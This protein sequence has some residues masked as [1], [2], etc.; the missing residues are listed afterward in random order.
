MESDLMEY[1]HRKSMG[2]ALFFSRKSRIFA[3]LRSVTIECVTERLSQ[4]TAH[5]RL[6]LARLIKASLSELAAAG[7]DLRELVSEDI[8]AMRDMSAR[9]LSSK[10]AMLPFL[11]MLIRLFAVN[12]QNRVA[13][14]SALRGAASRF[15]SLSRSF[16][17][18]FFTLG[19]QRVFIS[20][21][22]DTM[23]MT[24]AHRGWG[25][26]TA[27]FEGC[28]FDNLPAM[29]MPGYAFALEAVPSP[30]GRIQ[31]NM[32]ID[33]RFGSDDYCDRLLS[34]DGWQ[35][36][37]FSCD[38]FRADPCF[39]DYVARLH[40]IGTPR[41][42]ILKEAYSALVNKH[43]LLGG[44]ALT[45]S[46]RDILP[47]ASL[48]RGL[49]ALHDSHNQPHERTEYEVEV[50]EAFD[51]RYAMRRFMTLL[52]ECHCHEFSLLLE[53]ARELYSSEKYKDAIKY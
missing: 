52:S 7:H 23:T 41:V 53:R 17:D 50:L 34:E 42:E 24:T 36:I 28:R 1:T 37:S 38:N 29:P 8:A 44:D 30:D 26:V 4:M 35:E 13:Q 22:A 16:L 39:V 18:N 5:M 31:F 14:L 49:L 21:D 43:S 51:N 33:T 20:L 40:D 47:V 45:A 10:D 2:L 46:E 27:H 6:T 3:D 48:M 12:E 11:D 9:A 15:D 19:N 25:Y 32:L